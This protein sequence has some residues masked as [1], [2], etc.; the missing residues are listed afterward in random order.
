MLVIYYELLSLY[1]LLLAAIVCILLAFWVVFHVEK[2]LDIS[3]K[4]F[5]LAICA[6]ALKIFYNILTFYGPQPQFPCGLIFD[7]IFLLLFML[8]IIEMS[9]LIRVLEK[10]NSNKKNQ[11]PPAD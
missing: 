7:G 8:G 5:L 4:F 2:K 3:F 1:G 11:P 9:R 10:K 6:Y